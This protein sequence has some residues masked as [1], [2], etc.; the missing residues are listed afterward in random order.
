S[1]NENTLLSEVRVASIRKSVRRMAAL[2]KIK[3]GKKQM[4]ECIL[5][6][7]LG[8][9]LQLENG[10]NRQAQ[11]WVYNFLKRNG[12]LERWMNG[13]FKG[14]VPFYFLALNQADSENYRWISDY[15]NAL[16]TSLQHWGFGKSIRRTTKGNVR[17]I[18]SFND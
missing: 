13:A 3:K 6:P 9:V 18:N 1:A 14:E 11:L 17:R 7:L 16:L 2:S 10:S 12:Q 5:T 4:P 8:L 15:K